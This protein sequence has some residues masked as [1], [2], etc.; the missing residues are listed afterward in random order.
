MELYLQYNKMKRLTVLFVAHLHTI[1]VNAIIKRL[2]NAHCLKCSL[3]GQLCGHEYLLAYVCGHHV[4]WWMLVQVFFLES[5][6]QVYD[7]TW[8]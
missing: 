1:V 3:N 7:C 4:A 8:T 6:D 2:M 5:T